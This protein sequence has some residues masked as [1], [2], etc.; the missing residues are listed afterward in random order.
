[1]TKYILVSLGLGLLFALLDGILNAN[2]LAQRLYA[3]L[4]PIARP[5][6]NVVAGMLIDLAYGFVLAGLF[7]LLRRSLPGATGLLKGASYGLIV[8]F[9]RVV[10][11]GASQWV[12]V[13]IPAAAVWY[14]LA[15]GLV[16]MLVLGVVCG[17]AF[18]A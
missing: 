12:M 4:G 1:M 13:R 17:L 6:V 10:M 16:E 2:P 18:G 11:Y 7:L 14:V 5:S 9:F 8:W 3:Y 15:A